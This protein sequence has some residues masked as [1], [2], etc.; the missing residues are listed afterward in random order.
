MTTTSPRLR[1]AAA[2]ALVVTAA[3]A[4]TGCVALP[5]RA[6]GPMDTRQLEVG[7]DID[8]LRLETSI[9]LV[10]ELG[11]EPGLELR[12]HTSALDRVR[13]SESGGT[14]VVGSTGPGSLGHLRGVLTLTSLSQVEVAGSGDVAADF[15]EADEVGIRVQGSGDIAA[16]NID[17]TRVDVEIDGSGD[18]QLRGAT[19]AVVFSI[20]GSGDIEAGG[21]QAVDADVE[22][23]GSGDVVL[24]A[25]GRVIAVVNGSGDII[26]GGGARVSRHGGGSGDL[27]ER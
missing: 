14:I 18:V 6:S 15:S 2:A 3:V 7:D 21:L 10:V 12:G 16:A 9:D 8:A 19:E 5:L 20:R 4:L 17:A 25:T 26:V 1:L 27:I 13:I 24:T 11:S 22:V 23:Q